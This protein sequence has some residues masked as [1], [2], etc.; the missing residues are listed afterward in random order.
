MLIG[1]AVVW[2]VVIVVTAGVVG[3]LVGVLLERVPDLAGP[4]AV[5]AGGDLVQCGHQLTG[6]YQRDPH[7]VVSHATFSVPWI[8]RTP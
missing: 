6:Q 2:S 5:V 8:K 3:V 1:P 4:T 7:V